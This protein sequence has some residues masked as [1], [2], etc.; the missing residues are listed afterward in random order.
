MDFE[1]LW[2]TVLGWISTEGI[3]IV[4]AIIVLIVSFQ[5]VNWLSR[6]IKKW[7]IKKNFDLRPGYIINNLKL[8]RPIYKKTSTGGHF[9]RKDPD[10]TWEIPKKINLS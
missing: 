1:Q 10:F 5:L 8:L 9:G 7:C 4:I 2:N 3:K 6:T